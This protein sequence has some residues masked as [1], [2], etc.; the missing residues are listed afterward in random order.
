[1]DESKIADRDLHLLPLEHA[2]RHLAAV[3]GL[4]PDRKMRIPHPDGLAVL[5]VRSAW[6]F[7]ADELLEL[8]QMLTALRVGQQG[9]P[10]S[11]GAKIVVPH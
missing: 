7:L 1:M 6:L 9:T 4:D 10:P 5:V 3:R 11:E 2:A 8:A